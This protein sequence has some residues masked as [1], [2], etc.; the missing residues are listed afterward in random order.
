M[1]IKKA[2]VIKGMGYVAFENKYFEMGES[3]VTT[4]PLY[5]KVESVTGSKNKAQAFTS[6]TDELKNQQM[7]EK[8]FVFTPNMDGANFIAQAYEYLKTLPEFAGAE[9]C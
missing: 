9:D 4:T 3:S 1:A 7:F 6:F 5:I 8:S 2:L